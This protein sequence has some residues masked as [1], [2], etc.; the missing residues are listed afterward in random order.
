M[1]PATLRLACNA[2]KTVP[3]ML[4]KAEYAFA[5][6]LCDRQSRSEICYCTVVTGFSMAEVRCRSCLLH[7]L[8]R[9][10]TVMVWFGRQPFRMSFNRSQWRAGAG[11]KGSRASSESAMLQHEKFG[12][13]FS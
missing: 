8:V 5:L 3:G 1:G 6:A 12:S 9:P 10:S 11:K 13:S 7:A 4:F 2:V